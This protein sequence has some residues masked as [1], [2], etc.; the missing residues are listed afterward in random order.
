MI[1][2][3]DTTKLSDKQYLQELTYGVY[4][5]QACDA[6][7]LFRAG[8]LGINGKKNNA[9]ARRKQCSQKSYKW[10]YI[11]FA[12]SK[13]DKQTDKQ[14]LILKLYAAEVILHGKLCEAFKSQRKSRFKANNIED[15]Q[16]VASAAVDTFLSL[17]QYK[18][19][20]LRTCMS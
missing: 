3:T 6:P 7:H 9:Y 8:A 1:L 12:E 18:G 19:V 17:E 2:I 15:V 14:T 11:F 5:M 16:R 13:T 20:Q 4:V 10:E